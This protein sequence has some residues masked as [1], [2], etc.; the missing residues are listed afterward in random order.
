QQPHLGSELFLLHACAYATG[1]WWSHVVFLL[2]PW[3]MS[4]EYLYRMDLVAVVCKLPHVVPP[5]KSVPWKFFCSAGLHATAVMSLIVV[6]LIVYGN[7]FQASISVYIDTPLTL[8]CCG[9]STHPVLRP[10]RVMSVYLYALMSPV[11]TRLDPLLARST[12]IAP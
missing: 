1:T 5:V 7:W 10:L 4:D 6:S 8:L 9:W 3:L 2:V 11:H 12:T